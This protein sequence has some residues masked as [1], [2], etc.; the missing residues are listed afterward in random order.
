MPSQSEF[1]VAWASRAEIRMNAWIDRVR[2]LV[3]KAGSPVAVWAE[4]DWGV[5]RVVASL[6]HP[7]QP[8]IWI[9]LDLVDCSD[10]VAVGDALSEAVRYGLGAPLYGTGADVTYGLGVLASYLPSLEPITFVLTSAHKCPRWAREMAISICSPSTLVVQAAYE[11]DLGSVGTACTVIGA[12]ELALT[13]DEAVDLYGDER[14]EDTV[15]SAVAETGGAI[16]RVERLLGL[17]WPEESTNARGDAS[18]R[19]SPR[20]A[21][22][23]VDAFVRQGKW[24]EAFELAARHAPT[25]VPEVVEEAGNCFFDSGQFERFWRTICQA[26]ELAVA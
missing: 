1:Y 11:V 21:G 23:G 6:R 2:T 22:A 7:E 15:L 9:D 4:E 18:A 20:D 13:P 8:L 5:H 3:L 16:A 10:G 25:R 19:L 14:D 17:A 26:T 24:V 12:A